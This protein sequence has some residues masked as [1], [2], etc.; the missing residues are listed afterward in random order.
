MVE[1]GDVGEPDLETVEALARVR[2]AARRVGCRMRL[3]DPSP[4]LCE[5]LALVGLGEV[6]ASNAT[7]VHETRRQAEGGEEPSRVEEERD[8]A[9]A[10]S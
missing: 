4:E 6:V 5:L 3:H 8:P 1:I 10:A 9:D 2:L 7:S